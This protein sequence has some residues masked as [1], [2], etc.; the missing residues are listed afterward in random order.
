MD[1]F[2][3]AHFLQAAQLVDAGADLRKRSSEL[4]LAHAQESAGKIVFSEQLDSGFARILHT[5]M[6]T[7]C[8]VLSALLESESRGVTSELPSKLVR[9]LTQTRQQRHRW[10]NTQENLFCVRALASYSRRYESVAPDMTVRAALDGESFGEGRLSDL[11]QDPLAFSR[12]LANAQPGSDAT[13]E[14]ERTGAGRLYY[15]VQLAWSP[16]DPGRDRNNA[17]FDVRREYSVERDGAWV[18]LGRPARIRQG[19]LVRVDLYVSLPTARN[20]VVLDDPVPGGL[21]PVNRDLATA[22]TVD[23][24]KAKPTLPPDAFYFTR[25]DWRWFGWTRWSFY[26]RELRHDA[27]RFYS[28]YL[29]A[30]NYHLSYV[31]QGIAPGEFAMLPVRVEE[32]YD[33]DVFGSGLVGSL[34]VAPLP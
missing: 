31:A 32:M 24:A 2:G 20:F 21:E 5:E 12:G 17:G 18:K 19:D 9:H 13:V 28:E 34:E 7:Q 1:L 26:H 14:V 33:P 10:E 16:T 8:A 11:R 25:D 6:R 29:P 23:A 30:G 3:K 15:T 22:S 27:V 4:I